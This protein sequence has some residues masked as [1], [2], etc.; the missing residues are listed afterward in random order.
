MG[1]VCQNSLSLQAFFCAAFFLFGIT[2]T[3]FAQWRRGAFAGMVITSF[4]LM[5]TFP[6]MVVVWLI[7][8]G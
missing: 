7:F 1:V 4:A 5:V 3:G 8:F 6:F 2:C